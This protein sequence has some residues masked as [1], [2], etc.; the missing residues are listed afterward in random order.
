MSYVGLKEGTTMDTFKFIDKV[1]ELALDEWL[2]LNVGNTLSESDEEIV[3][4]IKNSL[5][6]SEKQ[7]IAELWFNLNGDSND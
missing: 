3:K 6:T 1:G 2:S 4:V 7:R 5:L